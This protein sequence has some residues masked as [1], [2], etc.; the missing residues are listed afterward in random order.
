MTVESKDFLN[1]GKRL[2]FL[3]RELEVEALD[4]AA[5]AKPLAEGKFKPHQ[6]EQ[7]K[8]RFNKWETEMTRITGSLVKLLEEV[9]N[10]VD[11]RG[12]QSTGKRKN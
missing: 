5:Y 2:N 9:D 4:L 8:E 1:L 10:G 11:A 6:I 7:W 3:L 12:T